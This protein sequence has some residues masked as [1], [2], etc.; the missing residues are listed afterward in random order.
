MSD[1][2]LSLDVG[3][4]QIHSP[5]FFPQRRSDDYIDAWPIEV[6]DEFPSVRVVGFDL[7][8]SLPDYVPP[9]CEFMVAG[10]ES[11]LDEFC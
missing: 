5:I 7:I 11:E 2:R 3:T 1:P 10:L 9:N 8:P 4:A 6:A